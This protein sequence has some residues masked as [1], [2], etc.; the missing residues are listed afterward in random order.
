MKKHKKISTLAM[1]IFIVV[2]AFLYNLPAYSQFGKNKVQYK[3]FDWK[4]LQ[5]KHFDIYFYQ[6]GYTIADFAAVVAESSLA[7]LSKN[8]DYFIYNRIPLIVFNSH[9]DFQQNNVLDEFLPEGV[10]GVTELFKNRVLV[11]FE[12]NYEQFRHVIHHELLH[13]F[14]NDMFYGGSLQNV[15]SKNITLNFPIWFNEGMAEVQSLNG[16]D[17]ETDMYIRDAVI[18][19]YLPPLEYLDGYFAYRGGQ[20]FFAFLQDY[21]GKHKIGE[22]MNNIKSMNNVEAG[23]LETYKLDVIRL[24]EKW[25]KEVSKIYW[26]DARKREEVY[27]F[28]KNLTDHMNDGGFYNISPVI[29]PDGKMFAFISNRDDLFDVFL[30]DVRTGKIIDK[31]VKGNTSNN[32]EE[33]QVLTP[34]LSWSPDSRK[35]AISVKAGENDAIF[36]IN[37]NNGDKVKLPVTLTSIS[38]VSWSKKDM[39]LLAF[40]GSNGKQSDIYLYNLKTGNLKNLTSDIFSDANPTWTPDGKSILFN[41]DRK[42]Y[43]NRNMIPDDFKIYNFDYNQ[44]DLYSIDFVTGVITRITDDP[45]SNET[46]VQFGPGDKALYVSDESGISNV[47]I[48][49]PDSLGNRNSKP[50]TNSLN[51]ISQISLSNDGK[52]LLFVALNKGGYDIFS[53]DNPLSRNIGMDKLEQTEFVKRKQKGLKLVLN[54]SL[55][56]NNPEITLADSIKNPKETIDSN[57]TLDTSGIYGSEISLSFK[58]NKKKKNDRIGNFNFDSVYSNNPNFLI[59]DYQ[60]LDGSFKINEYKIKFSPDLVY[61]NANYSSFYGVQGVASIAL[62][63]LLG[64][65]RIF[66]ITS[67]VIDLKNSDYAIAYQYLPKRIDF[68]G[69]I[70][71]TARF[72]LYDKGFGDNLYRYRNYGGYLTASLPLTKFKRLDASASFMTIS[73]EN[74]DD[75]NEPLTRKSFIVPSLSYVYDNTMWGYLA[76]VSG[77]RFNISLS[78]SP[79][80][81]DNGLEFGTLTGDF[82]K[83]FKIADDYTFALRMHG[84]ASI[85]ANPQRFFIGGADN[86]INREFENYNIPYGTIDEFAFSVAGTPLRGYNYDRMAGSKYA[87]LNAE[88][89]FP[90]FRYLILGLP[91]IGFKDIMGNFFFDAGTAWS[92][93]RSLR[94]FEE[95]NGSTVTRDLLMGMGYGF[96]A[97]FLGLPLGLDIAYSYNLKKFSAPKYYFTL[98]LDF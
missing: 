83:Y 46:Y 90:V 4:Y 98:G 66:I 47:Y 78:G 94:F 56:E 79:K 62:S 48:S 64:N 70:Y 30:A 69:G 82:R 29:S 73:Q 9:N 61:G 28:A 40:T 95:V 54:D 93:N 91:P 68:G 75:V 96:R 71:H 23:F 43:L 11:P 20:S 53:M 3:T 5:T 86:W 44:R 87:I 14:M 92:D 84:G 57:T 76:P 32:F 1:A 22:L 24:G 39:N 88:L 33:L 81:G 17:K 18:N 27:D 12:G 34:G 59:E 77:S 26:S 80:L 2:A 37:I 10:G 55:S 41:S 74:L 45:N 72:V 42:D 16:L 85:G 31:I 8:I 36:I 25:Q 63:D 89:R 7:S 6:D 19:N 52:K 49:E 50:I 38:N 65:H 67:M 58:D 51:P 97:V 21:Y 15:I 60:S 13:A 35:V